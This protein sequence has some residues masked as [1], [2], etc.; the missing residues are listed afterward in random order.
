MNIATVLA[1]SS[2]RT[3]YKRAVVHPRGRNE[4]GHTL[5]EQLTFLQLHELSDAYAWGLA[6][7]GAKPGCRVLLMVRPGLDFIA[8]T[9]ALFKTGASPV[10]IDPGMGWGRFTQCVEEVAPDMFLGVPRAHLLRWLFP[11]R[12]AA[13]RRFITLGRRRLPGT[14]RLPDLC[15]PGRGPFPIQQ[16]EAEDEAA[17]L[18]TTGSTGP[19]KGVVYTHGVFQAQLEIIRKHYGA[20]PDQIDLP[21]FPLFA[22]FSIGLGMTV[23]I[24][25]MD[26]TR[27]AAVDPER[28]IGPILDHGVSFS[29]GS[30]TLWRRVS[31]YCADRGIR[32]PCL[33]TVL[34]AGAPV[35]EELH[36]TM[37]RDVLGSGGE[38]H[39]PYGA[40]EALPI[41][42]FTGSE[43]LAET[44]GTARAGGGICVG[45]PLPGFAV[46]VIRILD[47]AVP[48]WDDS[49]VLPQGEVGE[50]VVR[51]P[52]VTRRYLNR[53]EATRLAKIHDGADIWHRMGDVG[54]IDGSGRLWY[55]GRKTHRVET[56]RGTLFTIPVETLINRH[57]KVYRS[58][59]VGVTRDERGPRIPVV[60]VE[61]SQGA[62]PVGKT[63][64]REFEAELRALAR[65]SPVTADIGEFCFLRSFPVDIR[66]NAKIRREEIAHW[67]QG[68]RRFRRHAVNGDG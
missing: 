49:L 37:L 15:V 17:V 60:V 30:P 26:P 3:P 7:Q 50:F 55:F 47:T 57:P 35:P 5:Y 4:A 48:E 23:V 19:A 9:F 31:R 22:L 34:M 62:F 14:P 53:P 13:V 21:C 20:S 28:I 18:F 58:A 24:P 65:E 33:K 59:L 45:R 66:H 54:R 38:V 43:M 68:H 41:A 52:T 36:R 8:L 10:L 61:P 42:S 29:F 51:G 67:V 63:A 56:A 39:T 25:D 46:R 44:A 12:F 32:L 16:T 11:R 6:G 2:S 27:P 64:R 1:E 40:T